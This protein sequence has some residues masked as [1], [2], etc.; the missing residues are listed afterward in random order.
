MI[1]K[2]RSKRGRVHLFFSV[3]SLTKRSS[4]FLTC[5]LSIFLKKMNFFTL[6]NHLILK[7]TFTEIQKWSIRNF[8]VKIYWICSKSISSGTLLVYPIVFTLYL[9]FLG[10]VQ[11]LH[12]RIGGGWGVWQKMLMLLMPLGGVGGLR[13]KLM[14]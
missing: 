5:M 8:P 6:W 7:K 9:S 12:Q 10:S 1:F 11:V 14:M 3:V 4:H 2:V 13:S